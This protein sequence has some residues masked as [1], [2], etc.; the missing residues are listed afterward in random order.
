MQKKRWLFFGAGVL[1]SLYAAW[2]Q[3]AGEDVTLVARGERYTAI[4]ENGIVLQHF[5]TGK[6]TRTQVKVVS[7]I[8]DDPFDVCVVF[9]QKTQ[10][11]SALE[12]LKKA[13]E[14]KVFIF[15][16]NTADGIGSLVETLG[17]ERILMG[18]ANAGG[19]RVD[20]TVLYMTSQKMTLGEL[21]GSNSERI[22]EITAVFEKAGFPV[23]I[24]RDIDAW[25]KYHVALAMPFALAMERN[26]CCNF[27]MAENKEDVRLCLQGIR[28]AFQVLKGIGIE[29]EPKKLGQVFWLPDWML[30]PLFRKMLRTQI[31]DIGMAR[32]LRNAREEMQQLR[33]EFENLV[34]VT[35]S[36][37]P[38]L[39]ELRKAQ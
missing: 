25:K 19:E 34:E 4:Q 13:K 17:K 35:N 15:M 18:H 37:T 28:E 6:E 23:E 39:D 9:V 30:S 36:K 3:E 12:V 22:Q 26:D 10:L 7:S 16:H 11:E 1:G 8:P 38:A 20:Q 31:A 5:Q 2:F 29:A 32:H 27:V 33:V 14:I 21:D 24:S